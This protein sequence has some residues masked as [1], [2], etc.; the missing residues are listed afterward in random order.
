M[1]ETIQTTQFLTFG[2]D[3][4]MYALDIAQVREVLD[5]TRIT[6]V[7]RMP[8]FMRGIINLRGGV[9]PVVDMRLKF[10]LSKTEETDRT[11]III[12]EVMV[13]GEPT[14]MGALADSVEEVI[15]LAPEQIEP[16]PRVGTRLDTKFIKG[17]GRHNENFLIILDI[18]R[19]FSGT[20]LEIL[21][22]VQVNDTAVEMAV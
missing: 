16:S 3:E 11:C 2:L 8:E 22:D 7:P 9:V 5:Y 17:M 21:Q 15:D 18:E 20:E 14:L 10:G 6:R 12:T 4:E 19:V 13:D 1:A